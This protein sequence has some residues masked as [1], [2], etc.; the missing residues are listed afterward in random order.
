M[1]TP[2]HI[3]YTSVAEIRRWLAQD[4]QVLITHIYRE[5]NVVA[6]YLA[7]LGHSL[8]IGLHNIVN[9]DSVLAYW[10]YHDII[11]VQTPRSFIL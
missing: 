5:A 7:N 10:L 11:G 6:D 3:H 4:W 9:P 2:H 1:A 8:P